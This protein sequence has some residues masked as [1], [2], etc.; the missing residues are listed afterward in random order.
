MHA[1]AKCNFCTRV[2]ISY[3]VSGGRHVQLVGVRAVKEP[4]L[5]AAR[6]GRLP[7]VDGK[8]P[9]RVERS[10]GLLVIEPPV[11]AALEEVGP[12]IL[13]LEGGVHVALDPPPL[14]DTLQA[15]WMVEMAGSGNALWCNRGMGPKIQ[16]LYLAYFLQCLTDYASGKA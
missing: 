11:P 12:S 15:H 5:G 4:V 1:T 8:P 9:G 10:R 6:E 7:G 3:L 14:P 2:H 13:P 16:A